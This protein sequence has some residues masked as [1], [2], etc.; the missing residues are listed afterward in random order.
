MRRPLYVCF[1][2]MSTFFS[3]D[4]NDNPSEQEREAKAIDAMFAEIESLVSNRTCN[5]S[6]TWGFTSYGHKACGG[7]VGF[8]AYPLHID[9]TTFL[10]KVEEHKNAQQQFNQKWDII[11]DCMGVV[12]PT[13]IVCKDGEPVFLYTE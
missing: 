13:K 3:C 5:D 10:N 8:I 2:L 7:P 4:K 11:S 9:T 1:F 12:Q 6:I